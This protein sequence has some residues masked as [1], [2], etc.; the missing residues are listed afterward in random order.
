M[1]SFRGYAQLNPDLST[2]YQKCLQPAAKKPLKCLFQTPSEMEFYQN[3]KESKETFLLLLTGKHSINK[4]VLTTAGL[5][6]EQ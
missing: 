1:T 3:I 4:L 6:A 2:L 5:V